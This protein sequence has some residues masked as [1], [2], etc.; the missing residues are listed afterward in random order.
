MASYKK[1]SKEQYLKGNPKFNLLLNERRLLLGAVKKSNWDLKK[2]RKLN[3]PLENITVSG[4]NYILL[5]HHI[6]IK[7]KTF[8]KLTEIN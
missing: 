7:E 3:F 1:Y 4:Y 8:K 5:T 6:N 2:A